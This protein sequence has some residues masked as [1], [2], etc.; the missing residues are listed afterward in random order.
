MDRIRI[1]IVGVGNCA[2][3]LLQGIHYYREKDPENAIGLKDMGTMRLLEAPST[4][5][6]YVQREMG[7]QIARDHA[8][9]LRIIAFV[10]FGVIPLVAVLTTQDSGPSIAIPGALIAL[11]SGMIGTLIERWLFF[12]EAKHTAMLYFGADES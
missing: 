2:S 6:T 5:A 9:K 7:Y 3:S 1:A 4:Q 11:V 8:R 10:T 12:A